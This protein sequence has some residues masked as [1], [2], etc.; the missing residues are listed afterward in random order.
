GS[1]LPEP[2][3]RKPPAEEAVEH[4]NAGNQHRDKALGL[5][6]EATQ[7]GTEKERGKLENKSRKE[8]ERA[9][10]EYRQATQL[11]TSFYQAFSDLGYC[12]RK[13][14]DYTGALEAYN[15][16]LSLAAAYSP[17]I[18]YRAEAYLALDQLEDAKK[19]YL[20]LFPNDRSHA[21]E[22][23]T[24]MKGW[25]AKRQGDPGK[26]TPEMV[27]S[28]STW[29]QEREELAK[30]TPSVSELRTRKW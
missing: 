2:P 26:L 13:T 21:D 12:L 17:A 27:Q 10:S 9:I 11:N 1:N 28:F 16:A 6:K 15:R 25:V 24:A 23:L 30:Q 22:L 4:Y 3:P 8:F 29:V 14:E 5:Q 18:E 20:Q 19:A 7:A